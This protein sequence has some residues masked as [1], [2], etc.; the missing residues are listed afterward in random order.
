MDMEVASN[1]DIISQFHRD[2]TV[3]QSVCVDSTLDL[4][5]EVL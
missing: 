5:M 2:S 1:G 3:S 4:Y